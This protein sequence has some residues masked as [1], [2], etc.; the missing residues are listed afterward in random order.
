MTNCPHPSAPEETQKEEQKKQKT[1][2][3]EVAA[4][5]VLH[6]THSVRMGATKMEH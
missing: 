2:A 1:P 5:V 4:T 6:A 3:K